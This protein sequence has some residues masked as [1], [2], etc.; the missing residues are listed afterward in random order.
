[1]VTFGC[2]KAMKFEVI[3]KFEE[4]NYLKY[5]FRYSLLCH[6]QHNIPEDRENAIPLYNI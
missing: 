4:N 6:Y 5:I 1:M 2:P 3:V